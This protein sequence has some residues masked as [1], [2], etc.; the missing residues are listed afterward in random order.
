M[1][2]PPGVPGDPTPTPAPVVP[3][4]P[5]APPETLE[6]VIAGMSD[7][8]TKTNSLTSILEGLQSEQADLNSRIAEVQAKLDSAQSSL[9]TKADKLRKKLDEKFPP[10]AKLQAQKGGTP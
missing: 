5:I 3:V 9:N 4:D 6:T 10:Q 7:D 8:I 2:T 1:T